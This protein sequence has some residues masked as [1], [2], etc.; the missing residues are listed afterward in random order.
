MRNL[1]DKLK[2]AKMLKNVKECVSLEYE[3]TDFLKDTEESFLF[4]NIKGFGD[5]RV[6]ANMITSR[7]H[8][9]MA[10]GCRENEITGKINKAM[11]SPCK[12]NIVE[13]APCMEVES[14]FDKIPIPTYFKTDGGPYIT[15]GVV[16]SKDPVH[17]QNMSFHR[18]MKRGDHLVI[19]LVQR[20]TWEYYKKSGK[21]LDVVICIGVE[22]AVLLAGAINTGVDVDELEI[23]G[24][25]KGKAIDVVKFGDMLVPANCEIVIKG[26]ITPDLEDE[27]PFVDITRTLDFVR[28]QPKVAVEK[29]MHRKNPIFHALLPGGFEHGAIWK[30]STEAV[31]YKKVNEVCEC[32]DVSLTF[33]GCSRLHGVVSIKKK[34]RDD[35]KKA[36]EAAF[37]AHKSMKHVFVV[38]DDIDVHDFGQVEWAL[39]TRFQAGR[40]LVVRRNEKGSSLD[41]SSDD[42]VMSKLGFDCTIKGDKKKFEKVF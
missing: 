11:D 25:L 21:N 4:E 35:G 14:S 27:G 2:S 30:T 41:P 29:V 1:I 3:I 40:D 18:M 16:I 26:R 22:P 38:D 23:A 10:L 17:G 36:I 31:I 15:S 32:R 7:K 20:H 6:A 34:G 8:L 39:A 28:K 33:G 5:F 42:G 9:A 13:G 19:R 12:V 37:E 24:A